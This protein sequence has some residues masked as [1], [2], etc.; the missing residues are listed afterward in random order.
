MVSLA[1]LPLE[2]RFARLKEEIENRVAAERKHYRFCIYCG[3]SFP[4]RIKGRY[5]SPECRFDHDLE[6]TAEKIRAEGVNL[7]PE[8]ITV[9]SDIRKELRHEAQELGRQGET[10]PQKTEARQLALP[11]PR[12]SSTPIKTA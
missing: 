3:K 7:A 12:Q 5:C 8:D 6:R 1:K 10:S 2:E 4:K 11:E 9:C